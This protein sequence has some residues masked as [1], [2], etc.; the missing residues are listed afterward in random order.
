[1]WSI[2]SNI[3]EMRED[4]S[5]LKKLPFKT[6]I[7]RILKYT[8]FHPE[9]RIKIGIFWDDDKY[10]MCNS[11]I[12]GDFLG[13]KDN[14]MNTNLRESGFQIDDSFGNQDVLRRY[15]TLP[16]ANRWKRR[17][18]FSGKFTKL[19]TEK[20]ML[21]LPRQDRAKLDISPQTYGFGSP[22]MNRPPSIQDNYSNETEKIKEFFLKYPEYVDDIKDIRRRINHT[23]ELWKTKLLECAID[24]W[25]NILSS[26]HSGT[27]EPDDIATI[28]LEPHECNID[29][30]MKNIIQYNIKHLLQENSGFS[31]TSVSVSFPSF[32]KL[33]LHFGELK[34]MALMIKDVSYAEIKESTQFDNDD[35]PYN[36]QPFFSQT[37]MFLSQQ[38]QPT[39]QEGYCFVN[40][41]L[42]IIEREPVVKYF[43]QSDCT[44]A[45]KFSSVPTQ[46]TFIKK[47]VAYD[48]TDRNL[49]FTHINFN[50]VSLSDNF[51]VGE[52][53]IWYD[54]LPNLLKDYF[55]VD[56]DLRDKKGTSGSEIRVVENKQD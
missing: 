54:T 51:S 25:N 21:E 39:Q 18:H 20:E 28:A 40:W 4:V 47:S 45:V 55:K 31:Q 27:I 32:F 1:M 15:G 24:D 26:C 16:N 49:E 2:P 33:F 9:D 46:Y 17:S 44:W 22:F 48:I 36:S 8:E 12:L 10:F 53:G 34:K 35:F 29:E 56:V 38:S 41:F 11:K 19:T 6:R 42:P 7:F 52:S 43:T 3:D 14:S 13:I 37:S 50:P 23:D 30:N 5:P